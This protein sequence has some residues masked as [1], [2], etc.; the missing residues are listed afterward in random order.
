MVP[1]RE[2]TVWCTELSLSASLDR[3]SSE[4]L[5]IPCFRGPAWHAGP[6]S[7][8]DV[9]KEALSDRTPFTARNRTRSF[10]KQQEVEFCCSLRVRAC[11]RPSRSCSLASQHPGSVPS[12]PF[13]LCESLPTCGLNGKRPL[14]HSASTGPR[15]KTRMTAAGGSHLLREIEEGERKQEERKGSPGPGP[16]WLVVQAHPKPRSR[17]QPLAGMDSPGPWQLPLLP[18]QTNPNSQ[19]HKPSV[20]RN[21][22]EPLQPDRP[23]DG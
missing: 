1:Q 15:S 22:G 23:R 19:A 16:W 10:Q 14:C 2:D 6:F 18:A 12:S 11:Q 13:R 20:G 17:G 3:T 9:S 21:R 7:C 8:S 5:P 4:S